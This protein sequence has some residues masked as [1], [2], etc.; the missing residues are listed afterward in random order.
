MFLSGATL[1]DDGLVDLVVAAV[2]CDSGELRADVRIAGGSG[3]RRR[4]GRL[5]GV[6][7]PRWPASRRRSTR[8]PSAT[9]GRARLLSGSTELL[10]TQLLSDLLSGGRTPLREEMSA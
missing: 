4:A 3:E 2:L 9:A 8:R 10:L 5:S 7:A 1:V 6:L